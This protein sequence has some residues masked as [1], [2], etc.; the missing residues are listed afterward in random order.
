M[1]ELLKDMGTEI[2]ENSPATTAGNLVCNFAHRAST[3]NSRAQGRALNF[4]DH[5]P[6][7][8]I[9]PLTVEV[10]I[11]YPLCILK[12]SQECKNYCNCQDSQ[13]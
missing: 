5:T 1:T 7:N 2:S 9:T 13:L 6:D 3:A 4:S 11:A 12:M 8:T 10:N